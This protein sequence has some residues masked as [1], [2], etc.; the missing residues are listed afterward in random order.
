MCSGANGKH[1]IQFELDMEFRRYGVSLDSV[2]HTD[3]RHTHV[4]RLSILDHNHMISKSISVSEH[5]LAFVVVAGATVHVTQFSSIDV[6]RNQ[7]NFGS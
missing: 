2:V 4:M 6:E 5:L 3:T 7:I 1:T